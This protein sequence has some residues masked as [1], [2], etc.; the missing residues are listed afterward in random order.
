M[1]KLSFLTDLKWP[2]DSTVGIFSVC[3]LRF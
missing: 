1:S 3:F 2:P